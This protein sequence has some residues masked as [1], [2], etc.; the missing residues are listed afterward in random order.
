M[1]QLWFLFDSSHVGRGDGT[2][3]YINTVRDE[4]FLVRNKDEKF[5]D[6]CGIIGCLFRKSHWTKKHTHTSNCKPRGTSSELM[7]KSNSVLNASVHRWIHYRLLLLFR[8]KSG[9]C[10]WWIREDVVEDF[11]YVCVYIL[12]LHIYLLP[13]LVAWV[14]LRLPCLFCC[15]CSGRS[16]HYTVCLVPVEAE[17]TAE[18]GTC[19]IKWHNQV[20]TLRQV[21]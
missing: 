1:Y 11:L 21:N 17:E 2:W 3:D 19:N 14:T 20:A 18:H 8:R 9:N 10:K 12:Y 6:F 7:G 13:L 5:N 15:H 16:C 4:T